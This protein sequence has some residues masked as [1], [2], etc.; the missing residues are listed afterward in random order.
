M[1]EHVDRVHGPKTFLCPNDG[2]GR[3]Y[4]SSAA[5][6]QHTYE[7]RV[8]KPNDLLSDLLFHPDLSTPTTLTKGTKRRFRP[9]RSYSKKQKTNTGASSSSSGQS[10]RSSTPASIGSPMSI[11]NESD[12]EDDDQ[13][14]VTPKL[15]NKDEKDDQRATTSKQTLLTDFMKRKKCQGLLH[16]HKPGKYI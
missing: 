1:Q 9:P 14:V 8:L 15:E 13:P 4:G 2:C 10:S 12:E 6:R 5:L 7:C 16:K 11:F 3:S